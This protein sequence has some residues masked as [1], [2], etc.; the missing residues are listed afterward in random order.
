MN[1]VGAGAVGDVVVNAHGEGVGLLEHHAHFLAQ[2]VDLRLEDVLALVAHVSR[3]F[4]AGN[5]IVHA[6]QGF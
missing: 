2:I 1:A 6:V 5:Q 3:D 4:Y